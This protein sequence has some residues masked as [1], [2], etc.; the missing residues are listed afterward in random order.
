MAHQAPLSIFLSYSHQDE[1]MKRRIEVHLATL[2][3]Q[4]K[5]KPWSDREGE[6]GSEWDEGIKGHLAQA[7]IVLLLI[8]ADFNASDYIWSVEIDKAMERHDR[9]EAKVVPIFLKKCD[10]KDMPYARLQGLPRDR[11]GKLFVSDYPESEHENLYAQIVL[12]IRSLVEGMINKPATHTPSVTTP[13]EIQ[14]PEQ[15]VGSQAYYQNLLADNQIGKTLNELRARFPNDDILINLSA[16]WNAIEKQIQMGFIKYED[17]SP[18]HARIRNA[19][20]NHLS[21]L[22]N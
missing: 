21:A 16:Q 8:S 9:G 2:R 22:L 1:A 20:I 3:R 19:M 14:I 11:T 13:T 18:T 10:F 17:A 15:P 5:I 6:I 4:G 7:H 12:E